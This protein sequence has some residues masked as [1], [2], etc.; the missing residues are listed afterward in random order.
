M[1]RPTLL[2]HI[3]GF[4][5]RSKRR[6]GIAL[7][8]VALLS[9]LGIASAPT[10]AQSG[11]WAGPFRLS[12]PAGVSSEA[13]LAT[14]QYG[15]VH[16]FWIE[17]LHA[18]GRR[19]IQYA[20][21]DG[22]TW[23]TPNVI[24][25]AEGDIRNVSTVVDQHGTLYLAWSEGIT[26]PAYYTSAPAYNA[27]SARNWAPPTLI[28][29]PAGII[30]F[31][32]DSKGVFH[33]LYINR[34]EDLG[35]Y[36][37]R[38]TDQG[39]TWSESVWLD[40][41]IQPDHTPDSLNFAL[42]ENDG[43]HAVWFYGALA[44]T[45]HADWVRYTHSLDGGSTWSS[46]LTIDQANMADDYELTNASP[47]MIVQGQTVHV[48]W[49][50]GDLPYRHHRFSTDAGETWSPI[51]P[52]F[53]ALHGQAFDGLTVDGAGRVHFVGQI[54]YPMAIYHAI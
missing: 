35:V 51:T 26:G 21:F 1:V 12:T 13:S 34:G 31:L 3:M 24:Y 8:A 9:L 11:G 41:D 4:W 47:R 33:I 20:R 46:P 18:D 29:I 10:Q 6:I 36:Y 16:A 48:I 32:V 14:D 44:T 27:L 19:V 54:R 7:W 28:D 2:S 42:D 53:G 17:T 49:A 22:T 39:K 43:L 38:S 37:V 52:I 30:R 25:V 15:F 45:T 50:A 23:S 40:P 5:H